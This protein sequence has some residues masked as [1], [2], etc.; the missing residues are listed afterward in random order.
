MSSTQKDALGSHDDGWD[1]GTSAN[2]EN[3]GGS[4]AKVDTSTTGIYF[5]LYN[6]GFNIDPLS[7]GFKVDG[8]EVWCDAW[9]SLGC[10]K[11]GLGISLSWNGGSNYTSQKSITLQGI[12][13]ETRFTLGGP[14][15][16]WGRSAWSIGSLGSK[17]YGKD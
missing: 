2:A 10:T 15:D 7:Q 5:R 9:L 4:Y 1:F 16:K 3:D 13:S 12:L 17:P 11:A 14:H 8:I 6:Y